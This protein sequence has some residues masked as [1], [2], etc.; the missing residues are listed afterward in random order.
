M[1]LYNPRTCFP[2]REIVTVTNAVHIRLICAVLAGAVLP[3]ACSDALGATFS[4]A[5]ITDPHL[6]GDPE[7][8]AALRT[9]VDWLIAN[10]DTKH[11]EVVFV[12][13]DIGWGTSGDRCNLDIAREV[14]DPLNDVGLLYVPMLGDNEVQA[15]SESAYHA[16][17]KDQYARLA[18]GLTNWNEASTPVGD[19]FLHSFSFD[20]KGCHFSC[21]DFV[22]RV[23][24][25]EGAEL[26]D[27][28]NGTWT[29]FTADIARC[30]KPGAENIVTMTHHPMYNTGIILADKFLFSKEEMEAITGFLRNYADSVDAN[31]SGHIHMNSF[32]KVRSGDTEIYDA[33]VTDETWGPPGKP[34]SPEHSDVMIRWVSVDTDGPTVKYEQHLEE[35]VPTQ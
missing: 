2:H 18:K 13:G 20:H 7:H 27:V 21:P 17:F 31:Y 35:A 30:A 28:Q 8:V 24:G 34:K 16:V 23:P 26:N 10:K 5:V 12:L 19:A 33:H 25:D 11:I 6:G 22:S 9:A 32:R 15:H 1:A 14:L 3:F 4:F 29:W